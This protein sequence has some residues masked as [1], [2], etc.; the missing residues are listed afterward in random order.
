MKVAIA[1]GNPVKIAAARAACAAVFP[2]EEIEF[3]P[4]AARSGVSDQPMSDA[5]TRAGAENRAAHAAS[6]EPGSDLSI[7]IEGGVER[8]G[9]QLMAFAWMVV[10]HASGVTAGA[11]TVTLPLP[12]AVRDLV[13]A[14]VELGDANDRVFATVNSKQGGGAFGLLSDGL[15]TRESVYTEAI[16]MA[17]LAFANPVYG[18]R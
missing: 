8:L 4:V 2:A 18:E 3:V 5:E 10:R 7:G 9:G 12:P 17:L 14:G 15:Y 16:V 11:R 6:M 13:D 1:S